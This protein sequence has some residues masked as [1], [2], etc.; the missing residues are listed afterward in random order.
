ML[1]VSR[2]TLAVVHRS[3]V[4]RHPFHRSFRLCAAIQ[5]TASSTRGAASTR[6]AAGEL[7]IARTRNIGIVAHIDAGKT[8]TTER[9]LFYAGVVKR[10][11]DVDSGTTTTDYMKE[12]MDRGITIQSAAVSLRWREHTIN[13]IDT[14]GHVDFTVEVER[15]MRVV[16]GVVALFDAS[17]GVQAQSYTV[18]QQSRKF[19]VPVVAFLN[20]MDKYNADF[21][22]SVR[23]IQHKLQ[24]EPLLLQI[25][26]KGEDG[27]FEGVIDVIAQQSLRFAGDHGAEVNVKDLV[28]DRGSEQP[29]VVE[30]AIR[31]RHELITQLTARDDALS[32]EFI[33]LLDQTDGDEVESERRLSA[34]T[35]RASVRRQLLQPRGQHT[36]IMPVLCG[37]SRRDQGVQ[38]L[39]DAVNFYLPSPKERVLTGFSRD[40]LPV[41]L[42]PPSSAPTV[43]TVALAF[44][45]THAINPTRGQR[46]PL[47]FVRV[48]SGKLMPRM[49]VHNHTRNKEERIEKLYV[50]HANEPVEVA[51]LGAGQI[52][53]VF[54]THT[55]TG[56]TLFA[57]PSQHVLHA[58][59]HLRE[60]EETAEVYTLEGIDVP[61]PVISFSIEAATRQQIPLLQSALD[62]LAREDPSLRV[63]HNDFGNVV[64]SGMGELHLEIIMS[65]LE[66]EFQVKCRLLRAIIEYRETIR[67]PQRVENVI[68]THTELPYVECTL[69]VRPRIKED[70]CCEVGDRC[71]FVLDENVRGAF[72]TGS[73]SS[74]LRGSGRGG[75]PSDS[76]SAQEELRVI[77]S[78]FEAAV[79]DCTRL[80]PLAGMPLYGVQIVLTHLRKV[81]GTQLQ[82]KVLMQV[83]RSVVLE[84]VKATPKSSLAVLE[85]IMEVEVHI[86]DAA[87]IGN[88]VTSLNE[89]RAISVDVQ[90]DGRSVKAIVALRN[91]VRYT[92]DL[93]K[94]V[95]GHANLYTKLDHYRVVEDKSVITR[96]LKNMGM[97][98]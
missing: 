66:H 80:G 30:A 75:R 45:V 41:A 6:D 70:G 63:S 95:K 61:P 69:E 9:M 10:V 72:L 68:G 92:M 79:K 86:S 42:P 27:G 19:H 4:L 3:V 82:E 96:I 81:A 5:S 47:V 20:K 78:C 71:S 87:Y 46:Q 38:P 98:E 60:G 28:S 89:H 43:T 54:L 76:R 8:T 91:I 51:A 17:A 29:H 18:L 11:G 85:P 40:G 56:D 53:A 94:A 1:L 52:G 37:A 57:L 23:S 7:A 77:A 83:A 12:E 26:L 74:D 64:V 84:V 21:A 62:E 15:A 67:E 36:T 32:E 24:V 97:T 48:Y 55:F 14:P 59:E 33:G 39:L 88:V 58:K 49:T 50:M 31:A 13:L 2:V 16:D 22:M 25:P 65:R 93:R 44:K 90:E 34:E 73:G 35:L